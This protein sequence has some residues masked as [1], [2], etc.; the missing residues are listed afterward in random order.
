MKRFDFAGEVAKQQITIGSALITVIITFYKDIFISKDHIISLWIML[1]IA[2]IFASIALGIQ[3]I[4]GLTHLI[5][6]QEEIDYL[7]SDSKFSIVTSSKFI[8]LIGTLAQRCASYQQLAF[9]IGFSLF[10]IVALL[11]RT[12]LFPHVRKIG[13]VPFKFVRDLF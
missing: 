1:A 13:G 7:E 11:D 12:G 4:G 9:L 6:Q 10:I 2:L 8:S 3:S 5:E